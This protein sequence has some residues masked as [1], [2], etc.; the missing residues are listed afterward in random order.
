MNDSIVHI[1]RSVKYSLDGLSR[2]FRDEIAFRQE[3]LLAVPHFAAVFSLPLEWHVRLFLS[4][5]WFML[6]A[7]ELMNTA[8]EAVTDIASPGKH[9]LA[10]KA[11]DVASSAVFLMIVLLCISWAVVLGMLY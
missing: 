6:A 9:D 4:A 11:K 10:K 8:V 1:C 5:L 3:C 7:V 2:C